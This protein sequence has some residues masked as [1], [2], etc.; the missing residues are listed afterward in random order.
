M[1]KIVLDNA[2]EDAFY[3]SHIHENSISEIGLKIITLN[4]VEGNTGI[5]S[6]NIAAFDDEM[7]VTYEEMIL[8]DGHLN[9]H[10]SAEDLDVY[11]A[12]GI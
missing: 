6:T 8:I 4:P 11:A 2:P 1:A 9:V 5:S 7:P 3:P 12:R 10:E